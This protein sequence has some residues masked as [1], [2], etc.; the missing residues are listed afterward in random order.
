MN[1]LYS[2]NKTGFEAEYW[3]KEIAGASTDR[4]RFVPFNHGRYIDP[5]RCERAQ[6]VDNLYFQ[7]DRELMRLYDALERALQADRIDAIIVDNCLPYHPDYLRNI[8]VYRVLR[9]SDGPMTAY[10]RDFA[11]LHAYDQVLYHS[12]A[13]STDL[14]MDAKLRYCGAVNIDFWPMALFDA[15]HDPAQTDETI[16][17][18]PRD[19]DILFVGALHVNKMPLLARVRKMFGR[20]CHVYGLSNLKRNLY[21]NVKYGW[22]GWVRPI[23]YKDYVRLYQR[24]KV[25][26]NVHNRGAFTVGSYRLFDLPGNG[27]M[28]ISDGG[29]Y[30]NAFFRVGEEIVG[31]D[32][33]DDLIAKLDHYLSHD[34]DRERIALNGFRRVRA[35]HRLSARMQQA[36]E[37]IER[38]MHRVN[39]KARCRS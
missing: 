3:T 14:D 12:P 24:A 25:G 2:F 37:L 6:L 23:D 30:L 35:D 20:R 4:F 1:I 31:Y 19:I 28:Q 39:W 11:Y 22:P 29:E 8:R 38:G 36:G 7:R 13:Y 15:Q 26:F 18:H 21:F 33:A 27:V 9:T 10:D 32:N 16:L 34:A 17:A 5:R